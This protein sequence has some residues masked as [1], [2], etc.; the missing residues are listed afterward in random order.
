MRFEGPQMFSPG[1][2]LPLSKC[3]LP[4]GDWVSEG[5][6][7]LSEKGLVT[8]TSVP[9]ATLWWLACRRRWT[10]ACRPEA[11]LCFHAQAFL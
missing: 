8:G 9:R 5:P 2:P 3:R 1:R 7:R 10:A 4:V 6:K 11:S